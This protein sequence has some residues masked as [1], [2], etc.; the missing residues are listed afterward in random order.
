MDQRWPRRALRDRLAYY[1]P[2]RL[3]LDLLLGHLVRLL[4][5]LRLPYLRRLR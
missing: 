2:C 1:R 4:R 5:L 3:V